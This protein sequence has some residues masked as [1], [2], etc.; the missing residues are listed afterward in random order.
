MI[1]ILWIGIII[2]LMVGPSIIFAILGINNSKTGDK[3]KAKIFY[4]LAVV[5]LLI[6]FGTCGYLITNLSI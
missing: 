5:Y 6:S 2:F 3:E 1:S 4:I